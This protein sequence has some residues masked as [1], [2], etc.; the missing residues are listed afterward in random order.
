MKRFFLFAALVLAP[1][2]AAS[3]PGVVHARTGAALYAANCAKC[4]GP[5]GEGLKAP[6]L[7]GVG[8]RAADFY[9]RT[10]AMPIARPGEQPEP[11]R[12]LFS[13][14]ELRQL[15]RFVGSLGK[16]PPV[17]KPQPAKGNLAEGMRLFTDHCAG[18]HQ[19]AAEGGFVTGARVP[20][21]EGV[22][23]VRIAEAVRVGPYLMPMF[24]PRAISNAQLDSIVRYVLTTGHP[25]DRGGWGIGELGPV[26]EGMVT[27][28]IA[29]VALVATCMAIG[30][31]FGR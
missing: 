6:S 31:R 20:P 15:I 9:L 8:E 13:Q 19:V 16:G 5:T 11:S 27:W 1:P 14:R 30:K 12:V 28:F 26:P 3:S 10:G 29:I 25:D 2:A 7:R 24:S 22:P 17:P 4:H 18:C 23:A 21:L